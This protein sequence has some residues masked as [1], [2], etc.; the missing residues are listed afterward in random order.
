M[1]RE[2]AKPLAYVKALCPLSGMAF[3][4][5]VIEPHYCLVTECSNG[6]LYLR[7]TLHMFQGFINHPEIVEK[8]HAEGKPKQA[9]HAPRPV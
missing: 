9:A 1:G 7:C 4:S 3:G 2:K 8:I 6:S 5:K